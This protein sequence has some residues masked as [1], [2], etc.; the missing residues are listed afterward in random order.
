[1]PVHFNADGPQSQPN[2]TSQTHPGPGPMGVRKLAPKPQPV[3]ARRTP[4]QPLHGKTPHGSD[5][6]TAN[7]P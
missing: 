6:G 5:A 4:N 3:E 1:M 7:A 2:Q